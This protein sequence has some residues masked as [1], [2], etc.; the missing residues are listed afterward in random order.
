MNMTTLIA[1]ASTAAGEAP[2]GNA[3]PAWRGRVLAIAADLAAMV[4]GYEARESRKLGLNLGENEK[5]SSFHARLVS[6]TT[7]TKGQGE[8]TVRKGQLTLE[9]F[10]SSNADSNGHETIETAPLGTPEGD[11]ELM[12]AQGLVGQNVKI[13]KRNFL[14]PADKSKKLKELVAVDPASGFSP[15]PA[16]ALTPAPPSAADIAPTGPP[17]ENAERLEEVRSVLNDLESDE[18]NRFREFMQLEQRPLKADVWSDDDLDTIEGWLF[19][20]QDAPE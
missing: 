16:A 12:R 10:N 20:G 8:N 2:T 9:A 5:V 19:S 17:T 11:E 18:R 1:A 15:A 13:Y 6:V 4:G 7:I 3:Y 14:H